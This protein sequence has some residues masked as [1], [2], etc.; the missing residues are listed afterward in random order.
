MNV[1]TH[2]MP[3]APDEQPIP[4][5]L[6]GKDEKPPPDMASLMLELARIRRDVEGQ[7]EPA[8]RSGGKIG[9]LLVFLI[10]ALL[11]S[12]FGGPCLPPGGVP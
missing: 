3:P 1:D 5:P 6:A 4:P 9:L 10:G 8:R 12:I 7:V 11:W 2:G